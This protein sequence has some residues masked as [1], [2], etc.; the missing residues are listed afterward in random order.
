MHRCETV[1]ALRGIRSG[2]D[3]RVG[4]VPTMGF[5][6]EGHLSLVR[7][8]REMCDVVIVS[9]FVNPTQF[10]EGED[11]ESYPRDVDRDLDLLRSEGVDAVFMPSPTELYPPNFQTFVNVRELTQSFEGEHRPGHFEGVATVVTKLFNIVQPDLAFFGIKDAQQCV[12]IRQLV[13]DLHIPTKIVICPIFREPDGLAMSSRNTYLTPEQRKAAKV[14][15]TAWKAACDAYEQ[16]ERDPEQ[17]VAIAMRVL[18]ME[19]LAMPDYVAIV[20]P[21]NLQPISDPTQPMLLTMTV[22][23]GRVRL[24]DNVVLPLTYNTTQFLTRF[25]GATENELEGEGYVFWD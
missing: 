9:I 12:V 18:D 24:L 4:L 21:S 19:P 2:F 7:Q 3:G 17:L 20:R 10:G 25:V 22:R 16:G 6:H 11:F 8:A 14:L 13:C 5:L 1:A 15:N 23:V